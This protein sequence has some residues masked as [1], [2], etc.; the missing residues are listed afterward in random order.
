VPA[1]RTCGHDWSGI[2]PPQY[3]FANRRFLG[4]ALDPPDFEPGSWIGA[5]CS[6]F[7]PVMEEFLLTARPRKA[8]GGV[9]GYAAE[10]YRSADG[11]TFQRVV[12]L[13]KEEVCRKSGLRIDSIEGT[14]LLRAP[15]SGR[16]H[17]YL[18]VNTEAEFVWGGLHW[19]TLLL[20]AGDLGGPWEA[21]GIVLSTGS[22][23]DAYQARDSSIGIIDGRWLCLYKARDRGRTV[24]PAL[25][26]S[27]DGVTWQKQ[28][29]LTMEGQDRHV[30]LNGTLFAGAMG[31]L[32]VGLEKTDPTEEQKRAEELADKHGVTHGGGP[33]RNFIGCVV[34]CQDTNLEVV[35]RAPWEVGS[36]YEHREHP[37]LGYASLVFDPIRHRVLTY[38]EA[39][40]GELSKHMGLNGTVERLL[41]YETALP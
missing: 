26:V 22:A 24:R 17:F 14:Q 34:H 25:A 23:Y 4:I 6:L 37:V 15:E 5:G 10:I 41:V 29:P 3:I 40:D 28:G 13:S 35:F 39:I 27:T 8:A 7:D 33:R 21:T 20:T 36:P 1:G 16:W 30:F 31:P 9:R 32:F 11:V 19:E 12:S 18:S 2:V 38:V